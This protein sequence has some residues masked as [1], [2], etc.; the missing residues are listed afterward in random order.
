MY[1]IGSE[2]RTLIGMEKHIQ[3]TFLINIK[4]LYS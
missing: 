1:M 4:I 2:A 3:Q